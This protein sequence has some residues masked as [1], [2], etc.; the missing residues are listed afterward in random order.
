MFCLLLVTGRVESSNSPNNKMQ[1]SQLIWRIHDPYKQDIAGG[2]NKDAF[3]FYQMLMLMI[4]WQQRNDQTKHK[5]LS[6]S[7]KL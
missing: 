7:D 1:E 2:G 5:V 3:Q 6:F 4:R